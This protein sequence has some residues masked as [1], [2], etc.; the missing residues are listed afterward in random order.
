[1][2]KWRDVPEDSLLAEPWLAATGMTLAA[3][4]DQATPEEARELDELRAAFDFTAVE[5]PV[6]SRARV[7]IHDDH[8]ATV[9]DF[10]RGAAVRTIW[11]CRCPRCGNNVAIPDVRMQALLYHLAKLELTEVSLDLLR[12]ADARLRGQNRTGL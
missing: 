11:N 9:E 10:E 2:A 8:V 4:L 3:A 6:R 12:R 7:T 1:M 5:D